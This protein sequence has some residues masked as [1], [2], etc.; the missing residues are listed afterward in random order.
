[1][2]KLRKHAKF[3][4]AFFRYAQSWFESVSW[5]HISTLLA[6]VMTLVLVAYTGG[7]LVPTALLC[8]TLT[9]Y[10][11]HNRAGEFD[12]GSVDPALVAA[13]RAFREGNQLFR[14]GKFLSATD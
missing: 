6:G 3:A 4:S 11:T 13:N 12:V 10:L 2:A 9:I 8:V 14:E 7:V 5:G 1:M